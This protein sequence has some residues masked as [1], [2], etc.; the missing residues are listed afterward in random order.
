MHV[1]RY[2]AVPLTI[3]GAVAFGAGAVSAVLSRNLFD[4]ATFGQRAGAS[5]S[6]PGVAAYAS[7]FITGQIIRVK[8][9]LIAF[10]PMLQSAVQVV[11]SNRAFRTVVERAASRAHQAAFSDGSKNVLLSLPDVN[12]LVHEALRHAS[13]GL[14]AKIPKSVGSTVARLADG[15]TAPALLKIARAGQRLHYSWP[16]VLT[17]AVILYALAIWLAPERRQA[18]VRAGLALAIVGLLLAGVAAATPLPRLWI[19]DTLALGLI[20]GIWR[21][22]LSDLTRWGFLFIGLGLLMAAGASSLLEQAD[23]F[24]KISRFARLAIV[25]PTT[26]S[27]RFL[28][29][30]AALLI[31]CLICGWPSLTM[32][33]IGIAAGISLAFLGLRELFRLF[34]ETVTHAES[35]SLTLDQRPRRIGALALCA[36]IVP[37]G[38]AWFV[39]RNPAQAPPV[40]PAAPISCN[41]SPELCDRRVDQV[42]FA[43]AHN[44]MSNQDVPGWMFPHHEAGIAQMLRDGVRALLIDIHYGF[45]GNGRVKTDMTMEPNAASMQ[46]AVG[47][48]GYAAAM[49]IRDRLTGIDEKRRGL[50]FCHGFCELGA[51]PVLPVLREIRNFLIAHPDE[52]IL[53]VVEDTVTPEDLAR[54]FDTAGLTSLVFTESPTPQWPT[55]RQLIERNRRVVVFIESG[56]PGVPWLRP[57]FES[58]R[59]TPYSFHKPEEFSCRANRGGDIGPLFQINHWID[60]TPT[61]RPSNA[62]IVNAYPF[63]LA[64][65]EQCAK[66]RGH[67]PNILAV[68]FYQTGDLLAVVNKLNGLGVADQ[69]AAGVVS[70]N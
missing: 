25:P 62:A 69:Q 60:T 66:E 35:T 16:L 19:T 34:A 40:E 46:R 26:R 52:V 49:R 28:W 39:W 29:G 3:L 54:E 57:A 7:S 61:P 6:D 20:Q 14:A 43:G 59:E 50:Y 17:F 37:L 10:R 2:L 11:V 8:P 24:A 21:T 12:V 45:E 48:E 64:R 65:A 67:L 53:L 70:T 36:L 58:L 44:A 51:Y 27:G 31:G 42:V 33:L 55:L 32:A 30:L 1:P 22:Y 56:R 4:S 5:L 9:D 63:L 38:G 15:G 68:D 23:P 18:M 13:P 47:A 41:G